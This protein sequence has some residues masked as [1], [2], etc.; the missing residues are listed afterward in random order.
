MGS[1]FMECSSLISLN[2]GNFNTTKV[3]IMDNM[4]NGWINLVYI[5]MLQF[6]NNI[7]ELNKTK[8]YNIDSCD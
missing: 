5:N 2:L 7:N 6:T 1:M 3:T 8:C 4:F